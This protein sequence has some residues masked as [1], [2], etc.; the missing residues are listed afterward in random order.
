MIVSDDDDD[1]VPIPVPRA[2]KTKAKAIV[3]DLESDTEASVRAM[4]D[5][6]DGGYP[7]PDM[8]AQELIRH[9]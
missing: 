6:D 3:P 9:D 8:P 1:D 5:I 2:R 4:M 7:L